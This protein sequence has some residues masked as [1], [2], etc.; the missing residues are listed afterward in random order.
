MKEAELRFYACEIILAL[1]FLHGNNILYRDLKPENVLLDAEGHVKLSDFGLSKVLGCCNE[2]TGSFCGTLEYMSPEILNDCKYDK[3]SDYWALGILLF[4]L[5]TGEPPFINERDECTKHHIKFGDIPAKNYFSEEFQ[6]L[7]DSLCH[8]KA[9]KRLGN[10]GICQ[11]KK[12]KFF[13]NVNW[14]TVLD[15]K[16]K[17][18]GKVQSDRFLSTINQDLN[19]YASCE[20]RSEQHNRLND[21][22][23]QTFLMQGCASVSRSCIVDSDCGDKLCHLEKFT[24]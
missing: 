2:K 3:A 24:F 11:I 13:A 4:Q 9:C 10:K 18:P 21:T 8:K 16:L 20:H 14:T 15:R 5:A 1:E 19:P 6:A 7:I 23:H 17:P 22:Y 12:H